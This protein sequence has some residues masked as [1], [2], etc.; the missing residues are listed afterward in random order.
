MEIL[1]GIFHFNTDPFNWYVIKEGSRLTLVDAGFPGH[2]PVFLEGLRSIGSDIKDVEAIILTHAHADHMGFAE[3]LRQA[4][5]APVFV[6]QA[7]VAASGRPLQLPWFGLLSNAWR[8][9]T[10]CSPSGSHSAGGEASATR[11]A[12]LNTRQP[13]GRARS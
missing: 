6:H 3:R 8:P 2:Y 7:D 5:N 9:F 13:A 12:S 4:T 11:V 10:A 1:P